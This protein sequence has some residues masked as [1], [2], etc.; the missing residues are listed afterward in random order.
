MPALPPF[1]ERRNSRS[2][3]SMS[4]IRRGENARR[5]IWRMKTPTLLTLSVV[6]LGT[7]FAASAQAG[8]SWSVDVSIGSRAWRPA[9]VVVAPPPCPPPRVVYAPPVVCYPP[10][11]VY[12]P[13]VYAPSCNAWGRHDCDRHHH[14]DW[15]HERNEHYGYYNDRRGWRR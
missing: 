1:I 6:A 13:V 11:P 9:P 8:S 3:Y 7:L 15:R 2:L 14:H 5:R 4:R 10:R 12:P